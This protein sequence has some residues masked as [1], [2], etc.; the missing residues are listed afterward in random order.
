MKHKSRPSRKKTI[1]GSI[2]FLVVAISAVAG[3]LQIDTVREFFSQ[4]SG[5]PANITV[6]T[7]NVLGT[8]NRSWRNL[9][10]GGESKNW[11]L[12][13]ISE[14]VKRLNPQQIRVDHIYDFYDIVH[15]SPGNLSFDFT[16]LDIIINDILEVGAKPY[17]SLSYMPPTISSGDIVDA[18]HN[19]AD[20]QLTVQRTIEHISGTRGITDVYYEVWNEPNLNIEWGG[21][22]DPA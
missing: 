14:K 6:D 13:P 16:Q 2:F 1:V 20:W 17:I 21:R 7:Q 15:G 18:P 5:E 8:L 22:A 9:A 10:Q 12:Q 3:A 4:A 19:W 11:R